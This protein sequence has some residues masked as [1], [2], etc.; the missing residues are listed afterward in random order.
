MGSCALRLAGA[1][2][3]GVVVSAQLLRE[4]IGPLV[5]GVQESVRLRAE[6]RS[7]AA[8]AAPAWLEKAASFDLEIQQ[9]STQLL[10]SA[11]SLGEAA[12]EKFSQQELFRPLPPNQSCLDV[13]TEA[14]DD[15]LGGVDDSETRDQP[16]ASKAS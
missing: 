6:G 13:F 2:A 9:G 16:V 15:A 7:R 10:L 1:S 11:P 14:L 8:G 12:P 5:D 3:R 4:L